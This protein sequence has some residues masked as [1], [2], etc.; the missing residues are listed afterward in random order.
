M[1]T[2]LIKV[3]TLDLRSHET[4]ERTLNRYQTALRDMADRPSDHMAIQAMMNCLSRDE[5][6]EA[7]DFWLGRESMMLRNKIAQATN[8]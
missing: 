4:L 8:V 3:S 5:L 6:F 7:L 1:A 2:Q